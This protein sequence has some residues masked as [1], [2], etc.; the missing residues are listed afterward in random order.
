[1]VA[2]IR[3]IIVFLLLI[4]LAKV[5]A[6]GETNLQC[7]ITTSSCPEATILKLSSSIQS[8]VA[9]PGSSNYPYN[10]CCQGSG[11]T[12][13]NSCSNGFPVFNLGIWPTNAHVYVK[14]AG[15]S[16]NYACLSTEDEVIMECAY[17]TADCV[18]AGY[19]T[20]LV[21]LS[22]EDNSEVSECPTENF[23]V[24]VCCKAIDAKSCADDCT[25]IS[26]NQIHAG[27]NGTNGCNFY[28]ATA[29]Q[30]CDLAQP[31]WVRDYD[32]TQE[33]ECAEGIPREKGNVKATVTCEK[34]NLI[35]MTKLVNYQGELVKMVIVTCG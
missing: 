13:S 11:F 1:M 22:A 29:M 20:C 31:G 33:V 18:S 17:T 28:D 21:S 19:D 7:E 35:K 16:G 30:V 34:E 9:L 32:G 4:L 15:P 10:L 12:V 26:D 27:C 25:F 23:P 14:Q 3:F 8:H 2:K 24:N 5:F 6:V